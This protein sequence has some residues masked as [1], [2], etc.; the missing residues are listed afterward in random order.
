MKKF[1]TEITKDGPYSTAIARFKDKLEGIKID[2]QLKEWIVRSIY[3]ISESK[4]CLTLENFMTVIRILSK[5][6]GT[7]QLL[8]YLF[9]IYSQY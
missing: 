7:L 5:N 2:A 9:D 3:W 4:K 1:Y 8:G 6:T